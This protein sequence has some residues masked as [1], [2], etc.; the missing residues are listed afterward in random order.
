M[1][2]LF[3]IAFA[4]VGL[5]SAAV[6]QSSGRANP[7]PIQ[8]ALTTCGPSPVLSSDGNPYPADVIAP[9][10]SAF[11]KLNAKKGHSYS[12]EVWDSVDQAAP[13]LVALSLLAS[14]CLTVLPST[15]VTSVDPDLTGGFA[16]RISWI[17]SSD[18]TVQIQLSNGDPDS[19]Y[20]YQI[21]VTDTTLF[22]PRWSTWGGYVSSWGFTNTTTTNLTGVLTVV[23]TNGPVLATYQVTLPANTGTFISSSD[24][25]VQIPANHA[26]SSSFA[27]IGPSWQPHRRWLHGEPQWPRGH[28]GVVRDEAF[29]PLIA[30]HSGFFLFRLTLRLRS[31]PVIYMC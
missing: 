5:F 6:A 4:I 9:R 25:G 20:N 22:N 16:G 1:R 13:G 14:D 28:R 18:A 26:G 15:D 27:Y 17:Q 24:K 31:S 30:V 23:D 10:S 8:D 3:L 7:S 2:K 29:V 19:P 12:V 11:F 21:R